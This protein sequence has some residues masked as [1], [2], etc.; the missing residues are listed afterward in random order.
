MSLPEKHPDVADVSDALW[1]AA[2]QQARR[3]Y[4]YYDPDAQKFDGIHW[5]ASEIPSPIVRHAR[6]LILLG[7]VKEPMDTPGGEAMSDKDHY[8]REMS[9]MLS[10][11]LGV[12]SEWF[13]K[14]GEEYYI[15]PKLAGDE[16]RGEK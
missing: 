12:G 10:N 7:D 11:V 1:E 2:L 16:L 13:K 8:M 5:S 6:C 14:V 4:P 3:L 9:V 15:C